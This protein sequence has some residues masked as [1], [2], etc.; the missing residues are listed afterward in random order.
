[1]YDWIFIST[2]LAQLQAE[3]V[4]YVMR[5]TALIG[6][7]EREAEVIGYLSLIE[8]VNDAS[9]CLA[10]KWSDNMAHTP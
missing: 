2:Q 6:Q 8:T 7:P 5:V 10:K 1:M 9:V 4:N 3:R